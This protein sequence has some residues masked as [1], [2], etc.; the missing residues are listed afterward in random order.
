MEPV[1]ALVVYGP[2]GVMAAVSLLVSAKLYLDLKEERR[3][4]R[5]TSEEW[6]ERHVAKSETWMSRYSD[7]SQSMSSLIESL[8]KRFDRR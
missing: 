6:M 3:A 2:L 5:K 1:T 7:L 4:H 8:E